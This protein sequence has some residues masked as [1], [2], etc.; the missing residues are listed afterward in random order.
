MGE[1]VLTRDFVDHYE[2]LQISPNA[3]AETVHGVYR[4]LAQMYQARARDPKGR[5]VEGRHAFVPI[6]FRPPRLRIVR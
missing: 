3:R 6:E 1:A 5:S 4:V 2:T